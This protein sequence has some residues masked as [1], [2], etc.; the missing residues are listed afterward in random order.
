M[1]T[2]DENLQTAQDAYLALKDFFSVFSE[3][4]N[5]PFYVSGESYGGVY[6]PTLTS[7]LIDKIQVW[8]DFL[9]LLRVANSKTPISSGCQWATGCS[10]SSSRSTPSS[11]SSTS[12]E[13]TVCSKF[14]FAAQIFFRE[15]DQLA[16]CCGNSSGDPSWIQYCDFTK[17]IYIDDFGNVISKDNSPCG[18]LT[19]AMGYDRVWN[20]L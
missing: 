16:A 8:F 12:M 13:S 18:N 19:Q 3:Y 2:Y 11:N 15:Y 4:K 7:L 6:V 9:N 14:I 5:R 10:A 17:F 20:T 1:I